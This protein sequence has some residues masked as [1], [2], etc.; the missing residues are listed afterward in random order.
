[1]NG[2]SVL[3]IIIMLVCIVVILVSCVSICSSTSSSSGGSS[4]GSSS[5]RCRSCGR[6]FS[7]H[8]NVMSIKKTGMCTNCYN[9][10]QWGKN[11][12]GK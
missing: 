11:Y 4:G 5:S 10:Y 6:S 7:D 9:N 1:M 12:I 3:K 8:T 2:N